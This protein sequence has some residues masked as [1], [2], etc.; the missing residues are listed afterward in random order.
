[1]FVRSSNGG[2]LR[3]L[4]LGGVSLTVMAALAA[5]PAHATVS[6]TYSYTLSGNTTPQSITS[7]SSVDLLPSSSDNA[8]NSVFGHD[9]AS[10][11]ATFGT[12]SSGQDTFQING[13]A[14]YRQTVTNT[15][16]G[17]VREVLSYTI[18]AGQ[19]SVQATAGT[20]GGQSGALTAVISVTKAGITT[21]P[22]NYASSMTW[23][24]VTQTTPAFTESGLTLN[25][26]G[27][28][29][30][31]NNGNY[32]FNP[33][34]GTVDLGLFAPGDSEDISY[35]LVSTSTGST[36][37]TPNTGGY[38]GYG[39]Y[40]GFNQPTATIGIG[41]GGSFTSTGSAVARIG[42][43]LGV[44]GIPAGALPFTVT[45]TP[46]TAVPE[47]ASMAALGAGLATLAFAR[48]RRL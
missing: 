46:A 38:G 37:G 7:A 27:P 47:P 16:P 2:R 4:L 3:S 8:G 18:A 5:S 9:Y 17:A 36:V 39:G 1:M 30:S 40:G 31:A 19:L 21:T 14:T 25:P 43:P 44:A 12:R 20:V 41:G 33:Y 32:F 22:L 13:S 11:T 26:A 10:N 29:L 15:G 48:R 6:A 28:T 35:T 23:N 24:S 45:S 34:N 42:D